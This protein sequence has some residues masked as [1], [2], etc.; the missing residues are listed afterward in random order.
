M[1]L[2]SLLLLVLCLSHSPTEDI[3]HHIYT[4]PIKVQGCDINIKAENSSRRKISILFAES[5]V[6]TRTGTWTNI[7]YG[8]QNQSRC[9]R[10]NLSLASGNGSD[11]NSCEMDLG[12]N[13]QRRFRFKL[14][15]VFEGK[16]SYQT[17][18]APS[19]NT[20]FDKGEVKVDLQDIG[21]YF[22]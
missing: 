1:K 10:K 21:R 15:S 18:Y 19:A 5:E 17:M 22:R 12:C 14:K 13:F 6:R 7:Y 2:L 16:T 20:F 8:A 4:L 3:P 9:D 11:T